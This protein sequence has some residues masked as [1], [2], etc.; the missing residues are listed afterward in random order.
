[1]HE[2]GMVVVN[3]GE[4]GRKPLGGPGLR[5]AARAQKAREQ[6]PHAAGEGRREVRALPDFTRLPYKVPQPGGLDT[7]TI[8][9]LTVL[10]AGS[11]KSRYWQDPLHSL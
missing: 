3:A 10:E 7:A 5:V 4:A 11:L 1:M 2:V 9:C 8:H 6:C